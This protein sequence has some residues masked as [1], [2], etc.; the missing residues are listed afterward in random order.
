VIVRCR[1]CGRSLAVELEEVASPQL[2]N[3]TD[4][5]DHIPRGAFCVSDGSFF[6]GSE[7]K[8]IV[9]VDVAERLVKHADTKRWTGCCGSDG[10]NGPNLLCACGREVGTIKSDCWMPYAILLDPDAVQVASEGGEA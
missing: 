5:Q 3:E 7:G 2:L 8:I 6:T 1:V 4:G 9:N 10:L